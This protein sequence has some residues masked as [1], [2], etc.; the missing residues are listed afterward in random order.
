VKALEVALQA[1]L[2]GDTTLMALIPGG[3]HNVVATDPV[4]YPHL[5]FQKIDGDPAYTF[6]ERINVVYLYQI[7]VIGQG[8]SKEAISDA[9]AR[10]DALLTRQTLTVSGYAFW[11]CQRESDIPDMVEQDGDSVLMQ[12][13]ATY[14]F[15]VS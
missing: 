7:R 13:G 15:E 9:L 8:P 3:V 10:V 5:V 14:R 12:V 4:V 2:V 1:K 11:F 6:T